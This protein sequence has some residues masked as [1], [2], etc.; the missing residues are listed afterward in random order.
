MRANMDLQAI[1][2]RI[3]FAAVDAEVALF[4]GAH[5]ADDGLEMGGGM[6]YSLLGRLVSATFCGWM[7][8]SR[9]WIMHR[10]KCGQPG[11]GRGLVRQQWRRRWCGMH[12][13]A[14]L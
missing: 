14:M 7:W 10:L 3:Q 11:L 8:V 1:F 12:V 2:A 6:R 9:V 13:K 5:I 4:G